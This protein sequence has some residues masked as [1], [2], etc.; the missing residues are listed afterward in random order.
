MLTTQEI[1]AKEI[2]KNDIKVLLDGDRLRVSA[3][4]DSKGLK[5]LQ[6][7]LLANKALLDLDD[8]DTDAEKTGPKPDKVKIEGNWEEAIDKALKKER[9]KNGWPKE[10][11]KCKK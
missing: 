11:K 5:R 7:I 3:Y 2:N 4:V 8:D 6:K 1:K 9:P 10:E